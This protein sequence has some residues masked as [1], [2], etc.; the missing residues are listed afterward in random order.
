MTLAQIVNLFLSIGTVLTQVVSVFLIVLYFSP[1]TRV[2]FPKVM[3]LVRGKAMLLAFLVSLVSVLGSL[4][5]S[6][7]LGYEPCKLCWIQRIF[8]YPQVFLLGLAL[9]KKDLSVFFYSVVL[10]S[11]GGIIALYHYITQLGWN[12]LNLPCAAVGY[13]VS[14]A[15]VFVLNFGYI[16]IPVMAFSAFVFMVM[17]I[18]LA[19]KSKAET[20]QV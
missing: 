11:I 13:S 17:I 20:S 14:C 7:I 9:W 6:D 8:M 1:K 12:P 18:L 5:Y 16:T 10:S 19:Q 3:I 15:K 4:T 2:I